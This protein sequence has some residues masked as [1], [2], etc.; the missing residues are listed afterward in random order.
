VTWPFPYDS[1]A[2]LAGQLQRGLGRGFLAALDARRA[3]VHEHLLKCILG[4]ARV[5]HQVDSRQWYYGELAWR[6]EFPVEPLEA[7]LVELGDDEDGDGWLALDVLGH[8]AM[9]GSG[10]AVEVLRG[11]IHYGGSWENALAELG[12]PKRP[13]YWEGLEEIAA[14]RLNSGGHGFGPYID[15]EP[16]A[17]FTRTVPEFVAAKE[18]REVDLGRPDLEKERVLHMN[19]QQLLQPPLTRIHER[20][21]VLAGR[22]TAADQSLL[23]RSLKHEDLQVRAVA[24]RALAEQG[25]FQGYETAKLIVLGLRGWR[26]IVTRNF[27]TKALSAMPAE[28]VLPLARDWRSSRRPTLRHASRQILEPHANRDDI[29]W[30]RRQLRRKV[31]VE[32]EGELLSAAELAARL[33]DPEVLADLRRLFGEFLYSYG[34]MHLAEVLVQ[35]DS[36]FPTTLG[37]ECLW[38]CEPDTRKL[39]VLHGDRIDARVLKRVQEI[40]ADG[41]EEERVSEAARRDP[42]ALRPPVAHHPNESVE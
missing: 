27:A 1:P 41:A 32:A 14:R 40:A 36:A 11:Y 7:H 13:D 10:R 38:D 25:S 24:A 21:K 34:R 5:D 20:A 22:T 31:S 29:P 2:S 42:P 17:T 4:E 8:L 6:T 33:W 15:Q 18:Q 16:F 39:G 19:T 35:V 30:I 37:M 9:R 12:R 23:A 26:S 28:L 3:E